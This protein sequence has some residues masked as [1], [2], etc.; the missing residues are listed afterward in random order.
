MLKHGLMLPGGRAY[1]CANCVSV[2]NV[3]YVVN[4]AASERSE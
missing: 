2:C 1:F 4:C 3:F